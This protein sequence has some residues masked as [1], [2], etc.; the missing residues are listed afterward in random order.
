MSSIGGEPSPQ[1]KQRALHAQCRHPSGNWQPVNWQTPQQSIPDRIAAV[2][3]DTPNQLAVYDHQTAHTYFG[4]DQAANRVANA[5]LADRGRG[6]EAVALL[7]GVDVPAVTAALGVLK[8]GKIYV[9]LEPSLRR[10][11]SQRILADAQVSLIVTDG[12]HLPLAQEFAGAKRRIIQLEQLATG[13][14][15]APGISIPLDALAILNYTSGSTGQPKGVIQSHSSAFVQAVRYASYYRVCDADRLAFFESL[16]WAGPFWDAFGPLCYGAS[17]GLFDIRQHGMPQ[18]VNWLLETE[19]TLIA[20]L[21]VVRQIAYTNPEERFSSVRLVHLGGDT[22]YRKDVEACMRV[23]PNALIAV[24][25]GCSEAGRLTEFLLDT[26]EM[27]DRDVLPLGFPVPGIRIKLVSED[28][29]EVAQGKVGEIVALG[30]GLA[31]GYWRRP[32]LTASRFRT[33]E[34]WGP[35]PAYFTGDLG[36]QTLDGLLQHVGRKNH[37]V[38]IRGYQV[39][40]NEMEALIRRLEGVKEVCTIAHTLPE[41]VQRLVAYLVVDGQAFSGVR[42]L[43]SLFQEIPAHMVPQSFVFLEALPKTPTGKID[44]QRLPLPARSRL[45]VTAEYQAPRNPTEEMLASIWGRVL[46]IDGVGV[47]DNFLELGG[48]SMDSTRIISQVRESFKVS[49]SFSAFFDALTIAEMASIIHADRLGT[50]D[51][52]E[53]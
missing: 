46:G 34:S 31:V 45:N 9:C 50:H 21:T 1:E 25:L 37:M 16:A 32:D 11:R 13:D 6:Q 30:H 3:R 15:R 39:Y 41:G 10:K 42:A 51:H 17:A 20:G 49:V 33:V 7:V 36:S 29:Q 12:R 19:P 24:G 47:H 52:S 5:I 28:G 4:L 22:I 14:S 43:C 18:L 44:R 53:D 48:D 2:A 26:P 27:L 23:F 40:T 8:A 35:E 38:K